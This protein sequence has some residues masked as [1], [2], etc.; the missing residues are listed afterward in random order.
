M[1]NLSFSLS[2]AGL[3][4]TGLALCA[5]CRAVLLWHRIGIWRGGGESW[6]G[7]AVGMRVPWTWEICE[8]TFLLYGACACTHIHTH[9]HRPTHRP[10]HRPEG[11]FSLLKCLHWLVSCMV[12]SLGTQQ[13]APCW[14][15]LPY[16]GGPELP[17]FS[18]EDTQEPFVLGARGGHLLLFSC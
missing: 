10:I 4:G 6:E 11:V 13:F 3:G 17:A 18:Y 2:L 15:H 7:L 16:M 5:P 9:T 1:V 12:L 8:T 14:G